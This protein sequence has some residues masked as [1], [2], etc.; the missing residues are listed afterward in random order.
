[1]KKN[2]NQKADWEKVNAIFSSGDTRSPIQKMTYL[3][4]RSLFFLFIST[5]IF[6]FAWG[7]G[8]IATSSKIATGKIK[9]IYDDKTDINPI[10]TFFEIIIGP[11]WKKWIGEAS[12]VRRHLFHFDSNNNL[13]EYDY[14]GITSWAEIWKKIKSPFF[15]LFIYPISW[16]LSQFIYLFRGIPLFKN[17]GDVFFSIFFVTLLTR[18]FVVALTFKSQMNQD[19]FQSIQEE[20]KRIQDK[21]KGRSKEEMRMEIIA[22]YKR[23]NFNPISS[24]ISNLST[25]PLLY[26]IFFVIRSSRLLKESYL[27]PIN[28]LEEPWDMIEKGEFWY[29]TIVLTYIPIQITLT[30]LPI[31]LRGKMKKKKE[32]ISNDNFSQKVQKYLPQIMFFFLFIFFVLKTPSGIGL[33]WNI[34]AFIQICQFLFFHYYRIW[35]G[36]KKVKTTKIEHF[37]K[38]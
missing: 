6:C 14:L 16:L 34:S 25:F 27:G 32:I 29:L 21:Y 1:M 11:F 24:L 4:K 19:K 7:C 36:S 5:M 35:K 37:I 20:T 12:A 10:G 15:G 3:L 17:G 38:N 18:L 13:Y 22:L 8:E 31:F 30:L 9:S 28:L 23:E 33:Y 26:A 2:V